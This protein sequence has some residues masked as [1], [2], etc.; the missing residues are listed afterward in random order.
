M[1]YLVCGKRL[2]LTPCAEFIADACLGAEISDQLIGLYALYAPD[3]VILWRDGEYYVTERRGIVPHPGGGTIKTIRGEV[4][5]LTVGE[6]KEIIEEARILTHD[7]QPKNNRDTAPTKTMLENVEPEPR[8][9]NSGR[10]PANPLSGR[11]WEKN[12]PRR[13]ARKD[14]GRLRDAVRGGGR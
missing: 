14:T 2:T 11:E 13:Y 7:S 3:G 9:E 6:Y 1:S 10:F 8:R 12:T 5:P 4:H